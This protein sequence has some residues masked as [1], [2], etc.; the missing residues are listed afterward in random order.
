MNLPDISF[1][2]TPTRK[3]HLITFVLGIVISW[4]I[5]GLMAAVPI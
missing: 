4:S 1:A 5:A 2:L 3:R